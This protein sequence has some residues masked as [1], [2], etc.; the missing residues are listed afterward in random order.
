M[1]VSHAC[2]RLL[3]VIRPVDVR[4][5]VILTSIHHPYIYIERQ[6]IDEEL[7]RPAQSPYLSINLSIYLPIEQVQDERRLSL[8]LSLDAKQLCLHSN[9]LDQGHSVGS[10]DVHGMPDNTTRR[11]SILAFAVL[12]VVVVEGDSRDTSTTPAGTSR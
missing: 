6:V 9:K 4:V 10:C 7:R 11:S 12:V 5:G 8:S 1:L 2:H 3:I